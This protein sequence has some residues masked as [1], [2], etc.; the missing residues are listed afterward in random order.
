MRITSSLLLASIMNQALCTPSRQPQSAFVRKCDPE[1]SKIETERR[2][3]SLS[4]ECGISIRYFD[5]A[6]VLIT[7][8]DRLSLNKSSKTR[9]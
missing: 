3:S 5:M 8:I 9:I 6:I 2:H 1:L 4:F 7:R